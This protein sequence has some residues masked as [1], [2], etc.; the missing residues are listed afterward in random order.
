[1][2]VLVHKG[3]YIQLSFGQSAK[4]GEEVD[5]GHDEAEVRQEKGKRTGKKLREGREREKGKKEKGKKEER[6]GRNA[7]GPPFHDRLKA[8]PNA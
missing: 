2:S 8:I 4:R 5:K 3:A 6:K 1:M 7:P